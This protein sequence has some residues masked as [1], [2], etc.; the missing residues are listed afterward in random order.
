LAPDYNLSGYTPGTAQVQKAL[1]DL[2]LNLAHDNKDNASST[3]SAYSLHHNLSY[4]EKL[5]FL[6]D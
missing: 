4:R 2:M 1:P 3:S 6:P 5:I